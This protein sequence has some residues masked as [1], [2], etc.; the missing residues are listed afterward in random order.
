MQCPP[1][2]T[3][4]AACHLFSCV[5]PNRRYCQACS[6]YRAPFKGRYKNHLILCLQNHFAV[7]KTEI[8]RLNN[9]PS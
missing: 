5:H 1:V 6:V 2:H 9:L 3:N 8:V 7:D 4:D